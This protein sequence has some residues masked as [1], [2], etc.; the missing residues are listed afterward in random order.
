MDVSEFKIYI[1]DSDVEVL[2][3]NTKVYRV[4][5]KDIFIS[6]LNKFI[7][8]LPHFQILFFLRLVFY[9]DK[10]KGN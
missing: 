6:I 7:F 3:I 5:A 8:C 9:G 4:Q 2:K 1:T 10:K